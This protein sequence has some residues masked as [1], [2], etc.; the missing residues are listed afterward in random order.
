MNLDLIKK[1]AIEDSFDEAFPKMAEGFGIFDISSSPNF[2][3]IPNTCEARRILKKGLV[4]YHEYGIWIVII[5]IE[6]DI[7]HYDQKNSVLDALE[8]SDLFPL[9]GQG[10][11]YTRDYLEI[12]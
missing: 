1:A 2:T 5:N 6:L 11:S 3:M 9:M 10:N 4:K 7:Y 12:I 8:K